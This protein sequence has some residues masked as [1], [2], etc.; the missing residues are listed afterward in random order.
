M[1]RG[2]RARRGGERPAPARSPHQRAPGGGLHADP[3]HVPRRPPTQG[4][5]PPPAAARRRRRTRHS[6]ARARTRR[7]TVQQVPA[8]LSL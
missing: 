8:R 7:R 5:R 4:R 3:R 2:G 1:F 6:R